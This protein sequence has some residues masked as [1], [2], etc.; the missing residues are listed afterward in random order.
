MAAS[1][2]TSAGPSE[3]S[4]TVKAYFA[5]KLAGRGRRTIRAWRALRERILALGGIQAANS[6]V[7]VNLSL[8]DLYPAANTAPAFRRKWCCCRS[9]SLPD[10]VLD[11]RHR[12]LAFDRA[13]RQSAAAG[14]GGLQPRRTLAA[15]RQPGI[16]ARQPR[17]SPG[18]TSSCSVDQ[19]SEVVG[20]AR[21]ARRIRR[22]AVREG[23]RAGCWSACSTPTAWARSIRR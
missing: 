14:A 3:V 16:P 13:R 5:L 9:T 8:F 20:A 11:A 1:I 2:F 10:V 22:R 4:A 12:G 17:S 7:K 23:R 19:A 21:L 6:Y 18:T 15:R